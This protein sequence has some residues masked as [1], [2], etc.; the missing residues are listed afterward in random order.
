[1]VIGIERKHM[2]GVEGARLNGVGDVVVVGTLPV[3]YAGPHNSV[4]ALQHSPP[5]LAVQASVS[6]E[7][8]SGYLHK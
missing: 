4:S 7:V 3:V 5:S 1:M 6:S 8:S 2:R